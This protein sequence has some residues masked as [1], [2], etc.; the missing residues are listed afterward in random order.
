[1][2]ETLE[3][4]I[5]PAQVGVKI[6][7]G[8]M[9]R[10]GDMPDEVALAALARRHRG[11]D[12]LG[13]HPLLTGRGAERL[14]RF[15]PTSR[16]S[17]GER[18]AYPQPCFIDVLG[19][20]TVGGTSFG[21]YTT[22]KTVI[23]TNSLCTLPPG[24]W[25]IGRALEVEVWGGIGTL[26]T[27]PGTIT[28]QIM[29]GSIVVFTTGAMQLNATAHTNLPFYA[30]FFLNCQAVGSGTTAKFMG[31]AFVIGTMF[32]VTAAQTDGVNSQ[33]VMVAPKTAMAQGTGFDS[34]AS[35]VLDFWV[36][37][38]ISDA[39]NTIK[40]EQYKALSWI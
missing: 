34:T 11:G 8:N 26:V 24:Y 13:R 28:M 19:V 18:Y 2:I 6:P 14:S 40:I 37:F 33:T 25:T 3:R 10:V 36:G 32:T 22:A 16:R 9:I 35:T 17:F 4:R 12:D 5:V 39:A 27:T 15:D 20:Q 29:L 38:S 31:Q 1:M 23:P 7:K 21:T 30:K